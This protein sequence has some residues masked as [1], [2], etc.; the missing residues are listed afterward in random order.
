MRN[1]L[2]ISNYVFHYRQKV[3]N[4]FANRFSQSGYEF[5]VLSNEFQDAG[6][7][8]R[9]KAHTLPMSVKGYKAVIRELNPAAVIVFLHLKDKIEIPIIH[10]CKWNNI[11][12]IFWNKGVS[13]TDPNNILKNILYHHMHNCCDAI[14]TYTPDMISNFQKKNHD[15]LFVAYNTVDCSDIDKSKFDKKSIREKY[16]IKES[17]VVLYVSRL[18]P[19]KR[20][21]VLLDA[22]ANVQDVAVVVM[23]AGITQ[24]LQAKF[25]SASNLYYLGQKYDEEGTEIWAMGDVFSIPVSVGLGVN[26]AIFWG[27]PIITMQGFQPPEI[28]YLKEGKTGYIANGEDEYK[29]RILQIIQNE[30][31]LNQMKVE[32]EKEYNEEVCIEKMYQGFIDAIHFCEKE[33]G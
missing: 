3:Y 1:I 18:K 30:D 25:D 11:P 32:C 13:D 7:D 4:Y 20:I 14:I 16:G 22:L 19:S 10:Y 28:Y 33:M 24:E 9:F 29:Q 21:D 17:K 27:M 31:C 6:Y 23:G 12:V 5:H 15:K 26:E 2:L 8:F